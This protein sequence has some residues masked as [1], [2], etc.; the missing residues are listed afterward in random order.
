MTAN[1]MRNCTFDELAPGQSASLTRVLT[2]ENI[3]LFAAVAGNVAPGRLESA[4]AESA[5]HGDVVVHAMWV[6]ALVSSVPG[7]RLPGPGAIQLPQTQQLRHPV[8]MGDAITATGTVRARFAAHRIVTFDTHCI[9]QNG[10]TVLSGLATLIAPPTPVTW[11]VAPEPDI[12]VRPHDRYASFVHEAQTRSPMRTAVVHPCSPES[13]AAALE[14][15]DE[16]LIDPLLIGPIHKIRA[17]A[18]AAH[19]DLSGVAIEAAEHSHAAAARAV[20]LG[21]TGK[22]A[23]LMKG[24]QYTDELLYAVVARGSGLR[25]E[26]RVSH[27]MRWIY[28]RIPSLSS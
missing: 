20:E 15:R 13:L 6:S 11:P 2:R 1:L 3:R 27:V 17:A 23:A 26:R 24:S 25:T 8:R 5:P 10:Q 19:I 14:A 22:V 4:F 18:V 12:Y 7:T 28:P 9:N 16:G 21:I